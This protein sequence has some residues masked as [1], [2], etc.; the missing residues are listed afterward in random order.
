MDG[1]CETWRRDSCCER[2]GDP[3]YIFFNSIPYDFLEDCTY[4]LVEEQSPRHHQTIVVDNFCILGLKG[5]C[6]KDV[7][8]KYQNTA[9]LSINYFAVAIE[10]TLNNETVQPPYEKDGM[11][12]ETTSYE[13][14]IYLPEICSSVSLSPSFFLVVNFAMEHF[15][16]NTQGQCGM[17]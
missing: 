14:F 9:K 17:F 1:C 4:I 2:Y 6:V 13:V 12:F 3:H 10:A 16:N 11:R 7:T 5:S 15:V 8:V